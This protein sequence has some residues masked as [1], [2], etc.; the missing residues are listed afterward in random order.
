LQTTVLALPL[1][2]SVAKAR[3]GPP[4]DAEE[5]I[6]ASTWAGVIPLVTRPGAGVPDKHVGAG[7]AAVDPSGWERFQG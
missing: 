1:D 2:E 6:S 7:T 4:M 3:T 5:D